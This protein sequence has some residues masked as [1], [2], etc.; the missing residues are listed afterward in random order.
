MMPNA[1]PIAT[2]CPP[3]RENRAGISLLEV[4]VAC[5][6]LVVGLAS[7]ASLL[8]AAG[9]RL[10]QAAL[11]DRVGIAAS[12]AYADVVNRG[13][14]ASELFTSGSKCCV[15]GDVLRQVPGLSTVTG[16]TMAIANG[17]LLDQR[18]D[19]Q[20][21]FSLEDELVY[22]SGTTGAG[23]AS[24]F[25]NGGLGPREYR[26]NV[27]W[28]AMLAPATNVTNPSDLAGTNAILSIAI[29]RKENPPQLISGTIAPF[30]GLTTLSGS[31]S[32][33]LMQIGNATAAEPIRKEYFP[34]CSFILAL[35]RAGAAPTVRPAW[36]RITSSWMSPSGSFVALDY[37]STNAS[38]YVN[39]SGA[40]RS[41]SAIV[42][43][44]LMRVDRYP[45][46][47]D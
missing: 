1:L 19:A 43:D 14:I 30:P 26:D 8:P 28:G 37:G 7:L 13:L 40:N 15:F 31:T 46:R 45:V 6:I 18:I 32:N 2:A 38:D 9:A 41:L 44:G 25:M 24:S 5:G 39:V 12:N 16:S 33:M 34:G 17:T 29:F 42:F 35:P 4:L 20:R 22:T 3:C 27:C 11:E 47:L 21:G 10:A 23:V 36:V